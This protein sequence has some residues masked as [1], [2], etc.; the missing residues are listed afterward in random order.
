MSNLRF[1]FRT[2]GPRNSWRVGSWGARA[3]RG[4]HTHPLDSGVRTR[5]QF[6]SRPSR[7]IPSF[8]S[9]R[10]VIFCCLLFRLF[11]LSAYLRTALEFTPD[12][13]PLVLAPMLYAEPQ[14]LP[15]SKLFVDAHSLPR[16]IVCSSCTLLAVYS[17]QTDWTSCALCCSRT[18][19]SQTW[20]RSSDLRVFP[21]TCFHMALSITYVTN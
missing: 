5:F 14:D 11:F 7:L 8:P 17:L 16:A 9:Q 2:T 12:R 4:P 19:R 13:V 3:E 1:I 21:R 20:W 18:W 10:S 6:Q 15:M